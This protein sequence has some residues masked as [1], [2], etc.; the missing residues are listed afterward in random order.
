[1]FEIR[2]MELA[3]LN[4]LS[5][6]YRSSKPSTGRAFSS[7]PFTEWIVNNERLL[8]VADSGTKLLGF[9]VVRPK[10]EEASIDLFCYDKRSRAKNL[11]D[12]LLEHAERFAEAKQMSIFLPK[13]DKLIPFFKKKGYKVYDEIK[14]LYGKGKDAY[15]FIKKLERSA[16]KPKKKVKK[17]KEED[18]LLKENLKK[19]D[20]YLDF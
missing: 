8:L 13:G 3:D 6:L 19:L 18:D 5:K 15:L 7:Y 17:Q 14:D 2:W 4:K 16:K 12:A 9:I 1:M 20:A 10:G 11:K